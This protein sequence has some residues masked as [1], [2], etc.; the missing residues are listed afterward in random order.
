MLR[1]P[2]DVVVLKGPSWWTA[3]HILVLLAL[4][5]AATL[6][7]LG[8]VMVLRRH[9]QKQ[10]NL[11][12]ESESRFRHMALHDALTGLATRLLLEDRLST[13]VEAA[14]R[15]HTGLTIAATKSC[16][17]APIASRR[18]C[19]RAIQLPDWAETNSSCSSPI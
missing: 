15:H 9:V 5:L 6:C 4:A 8:W 2:Q 12:R 17:S 16:A 19:A 14:K 18:P 10:A 1:T 13:A 7:V 11:L 3:G